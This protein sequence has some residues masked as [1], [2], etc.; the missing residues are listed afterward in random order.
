M[1]TEFKA[2]FLTACLLALAVGIML[3]LIEQ[4]QIPQIIVVK[5]DH[6]LAPHEIAQLQEEA[7][8]ITREAADDS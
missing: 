4:M 7:R 2:T 1:T 6:D 3:A 5:T 8:R